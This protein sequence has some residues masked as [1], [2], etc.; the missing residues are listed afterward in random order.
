[1]RK[2]KYVLSIC[3]TSLCT[4]CSTTTTT[5]TDIE[6]ETPSPTILATP[7]TSPDT[8][9]ST[10]LVATQTPMPKLALSNTEILDSPVFD[11]NTPVGSHGKLHV[12][13]I[14]IKDIHDEVFQF[15]GVSTHGVQWFSEYTSSETFKELRDNFNINAIRL[16]LYADVESNYPENQDSYTKILEDAIDNATSLGLYVVIDWHIL[17]D[18]SPTIGEDN[19]KNFFNYFSYKYQNYDNVL[20]EICNEP[21]GSDATWDEC[22]KPYADNIITTIRANSPNSIIIVGTPKWCQ[23]PLSVVRNKIDDINTVY[24]FHFYANSHGLPLRQTLTSAITKYELPML[25]SEFGTCDSS[26]A[27]EINITSSNEWLDYIDENN[28]G[29]FIWNLSDKDESSS[30]LV[31]DAPPFGWDDDDLTPN[32]HFIR[33]RLHSY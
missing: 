7:T 10:D 4:G 28:I 2:L 12:D 30:I 5:T 32:G 19:A 20:F 18:G 17:A 33:D 23:S 16:A 26:G 3:L 24:S 11:I 15:K 13:G 27:G 14:H 21:N 6:V 9:T 29:W 22:I 1:M 8:S 31:P 25:I